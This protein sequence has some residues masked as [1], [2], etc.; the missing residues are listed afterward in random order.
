PQAGNVRA[1]EM[2]KPRCVVGFVGC[3]ANG[4]I[5]ARNSGQAVLRLQGTAY[6]I[7]IMFGI[8]T[9][10]GTFNTTFQVVQIACTQAHIGTTCNG[11]AVVD[12]ATGIDIH[13]VGGNQTAVGANPNVPRTQVDLGDQCCVEG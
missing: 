5:M 9:Q 10:V 2:A 11:T 6:V 3:C 7:E 1:A 12:V 13:A 8:Q 4:Q